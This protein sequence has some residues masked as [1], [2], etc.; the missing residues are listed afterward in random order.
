MSKMNGGARDH[1]FDRRDFLRLAG[2]GSAAFFFQDLWSASALGRP[3]DAAIG[4]GKTA[5]RCLVL[6]MA[7]GPS[8]LETF[9]PK[10]GM[11]TGGPFQKIP[12]KVDG[13]QIAELLPGV[14]ARFEDLCLIRSMTSKE[15]SHARARYLVHTGYSPNPTVH[16]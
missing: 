12:T 9:D 3:V 4:K 1:G 6:W 11:P 8:Q 14:A 2:L 15:G 5:K 13:V 10:P 7:G 16:H